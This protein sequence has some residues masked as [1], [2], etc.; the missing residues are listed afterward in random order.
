MTASTADRAAAKAAP[1]AQPL[2]WEHPRL[3]V[4]AMPDRVSVEA[5]AFNHSADFAARLLA[6]PRESAAARVAAAG[7]ALRDRAASTDTTKAAASARRNLA[8]ARAEVEKN[9]QPAEKADAEVAA[10]IAA[11]RNPSEALE[12]HEKALA[13]LSRSRAWKPA[14]SRPWS[15]W[16]P[17]N[18]GSWR[19]WPRPPPWSCGRRPTRS[20][21][22]PG[23]PSSGRWSRT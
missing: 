18:S 1:A 8:L 4:N 2:L 11:G 23:W 14:P 12:R 17:P 20:S 5:R 21:R 15:R 16:R 7:R 9:S 13:A 10:A 19:P 3:V 22:R 6:S